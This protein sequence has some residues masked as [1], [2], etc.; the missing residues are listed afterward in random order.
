MNEKIKI[1]TAA[2]EDALLKGNPEILAAIKEAAVRAKEYEL[3]ARF[4]D[5][6][7]QVINDNCVETSGDEDEFR[8]LLAAR[9]MV[10]L[11]T[12]SASVKWLINPKQMAEE[13]VASADAL[14]A[15]LKKEKQ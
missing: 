15:E 3:G 1:A 7:K 9:I 12:S 4:R 8:K 11:V 14:I 5:I 6:E 2:L 13:A 10:A